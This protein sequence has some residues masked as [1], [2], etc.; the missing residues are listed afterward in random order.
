MKKG[1]RILTACILCL[2]CLWAEALPARAAQE[3]EPLTVLVKGDSQEPFMGNFLRGKG[4]VLVDLNTVATMAKDIRLG[5]SLDG[6]SVA[7]YREAGS[8]QYA[9]EDIQENA[10]GM[11]VPLSDT[12]E[13]LGLNGEGD[14]EETLLKVFP[15][16]EDTAFTGLLA[17]NWL[18]TAENAKDMS[19]YWPE[20]AVRAMLPVL[21]VTVRASWEN[22]A[23][24][25][26]VQVD[27]LLEGTY[28]DGAVA[29]M[30]ESKDVYIHSVDYSP[31]ATVQHREN[32]TNLEITQLSGDYT[33]T[34]EWGETET[35]PGLTYA[36]I[37]LKI[38]IA[39]PVETLLTLAADPESVE[40]GVELT[41]PA[42]F[43]TRGTSGVW[44][45]GFHLD[46]G[47][48][49]TLAGE[50]V[51]P[52]EGDREVTYGEDG[53]MQSLAEYDHKGRKIL[54]EWY[55]E[56]TCTAYTYWE[57]DSRENLVSIRYRNLLEPEEVEIRFE[58][59]YD[60]NDQLTKVTMHN[61]RGKLLAEGESP[62]AA[63][64]QLGLGTLVEE[65]L[66]PQRQSMEEDMGM[67]GQ[68][69]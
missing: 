68:E 8:I 47:Q 24:E 1:L 32:S 50:P 2:C 30:A 45:Y 62:Y 15:L 9:L 53:Q 11:Y 14:R 59:Q 33:L 28:L 20:P 37:A 25:T 48:L 60:R 51:F 58:Y 61:A 31:V 5:L 7:L 35:L 23:S 65:S 29:E 49:L 43:Y 34:I 55:E 63:A 17:E 64:N 56:G 6:K 36:D 57:Y 27:V 16:E 4:R 10:N 44:Y 41:D 69:K 46:N 66:H 19:L 67:P 40:E 3:W 22:P 42:E 12:L 26:P 18:K 39:T 13:A 38:E 54:S 52:E 21:P